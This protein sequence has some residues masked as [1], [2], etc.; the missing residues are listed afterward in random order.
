MDRQGRRTAGFKRVDTGDQIR[1]ASTVLLGFMS[2]AMF[3]ALNVFPVEI[4]SLSL[5]LLPLG[6]LRLLA[7][8]SLHAV[9][10]SFPIL[11]FLFL[12]PFVR[13]LLT[14]VIPLLLSLMPFV[15]FIVPLSHFFLPFV[16]PLLLSCAIRPVYHSNRPFFPSTCDPTSALSPFVVCVVFGV[17]RAFYDTSVSFHLEVPI[18]T[19]LVTNF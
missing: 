17:K 10:F 7:R 18:S 6:S 13:F 19:Y 3:L 5:Q 12:P 4:H 11:F 9:L 2:G 8:P 16:L 1:K 14:L 15:L